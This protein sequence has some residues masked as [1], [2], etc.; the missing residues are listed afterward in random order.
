MSSTKGHSGEI[1]TRKLTK[2]VSVAVLMGLGLLPGCASY[3]C[4]NVCDPCEVE[5]ACYTEDGMCDS[6][7]GSGGWDWRS[8]WAGWQ[9]RI[10]GRWRSHAIPEELPLGVVNRAHYQAMET[11]AEAV[12]F[13]LYDHDFVLNTA[14]LTSD[15]KDKVLEIAARMRSA[16]FPV[17][18]ERTENNSDPELDSYRRNLIAQILTDLGNPDAD[19]RTVVS[20]SYGPGYNSIESERDWYQHIGGGG[21]N[22]NNF[23]NNNGVG[24]TFGGGGFGGF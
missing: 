12:D 17:I 2:P 4:G 3:P 20:R 5:G 1:M 9:A 16:P 7:T 8:S 15:G 6:G 11:N 19:Q 22:N 14:E 13:I 24:T 23:G 10:L 18:V 21:Q